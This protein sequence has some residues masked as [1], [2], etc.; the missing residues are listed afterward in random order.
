MTFVSV[1]RRVKDTA[2]VVVFS[3]GTILFTGFA[4]SVTVSMVTHDLWWPHRLMG[5]AWAAFYG[6]CAYGS[7]SITRRVYRRGVAAAG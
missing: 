2:L 6:F 3:L 5:L 4:L 1:W 7:A